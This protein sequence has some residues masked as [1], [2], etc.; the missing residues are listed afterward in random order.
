MD[1]LIEAHVLSAI[2]MLMT[3]IYSFSSDLSSELQTHIQ[4]LSLNLCLD[5]SQN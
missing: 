4:L 3:Q 2:S 1:D 5:A